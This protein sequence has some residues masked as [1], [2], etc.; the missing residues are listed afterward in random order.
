M[1][2][3]LFS[4]LLIASTYY[5]NAQVKYPKTDVIPVENKYHNF[6]ITD[7]YQWLEDK[8][9]PKVKEWSHTQHNFTLYKIKK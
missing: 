6:K 8:S 2:K 5:M 9:D 7:P 3:I 4:I 1:K